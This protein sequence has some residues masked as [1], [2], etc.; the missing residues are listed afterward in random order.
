MD[1][2]SFIFVS[3][4]GIAARNARAADPGPFVSSDVGAL[5]SVLVHTPGKEGR[6][7]LGLGQGSASL[8]NQPLSEEAAEEHRG[9]VQALRQ[10]GAE[11][12]EVRQVL[13]EAAVAARAKGA[14]KPWLRAWVP[15]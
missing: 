9:F 1:R 2:R 13:D 4:A 10:G 6:R 11:T 7:G 3:I 5:K 8:G 12:V 14:L 15:S